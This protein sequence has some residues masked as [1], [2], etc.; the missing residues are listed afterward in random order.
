MKVA[1]ACGGTGGH[2]FPG[3]TAA[4]ELRRR[5]HEVTLWLAGARPEGDA[6]AGWP[7]PVEQIRAGGFQS[8]RLLSNLA[9]AWSLLMAIP[10]CRRRMKRNR[11]DVLLAMGSYASVGPSIAARSLRIPLVLHE[12][13]AVPGRAVSLL[14]RY[15]SAVAVTFDAAAAHL[16]SAT[17]VKTGL[18]IRTD[19]DDRF[20]D[21]VLRRGVFT[22][23]VMGGSQGAQRLNEIVPEA[24][25]RL[26]A[27]GAHLQ[28]VHL[29]GRHDAD[30][31][32]SQY[33]AAGLSHVVFPF[34]K[35][36]GKAYNAADL[37]VSRSGAA[38]CMELATRGVPCLL[39]PFPFARR[40]HQT[41]N[42]AEM[43]RCGGA[44]TIAQRDLTAQWLADY[45]EPCM[46]QPAK[47]VTMR[48]ALKAVAVPDATARLADLV[49]R[50][51]GRR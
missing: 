42:A 11:P 9:A 43:A 49:E 36:M 32:H 23:L 34:L 39:V 22:V 26:H 45:V 33:A 4:N 46:R 12:A 31:V 6:L 19:L 40:D 16:P 13:N 28:V 14:S 41:A 30:R 15:A 38:S 48:Q 44:D 37:A 10:A 35:E 25:I 17:T 7:G 3:L 21:G 51:G 24:L 27:R 50:V 47:L 20:D 18:P 8:A 2:I 1:V 29:A 5:G